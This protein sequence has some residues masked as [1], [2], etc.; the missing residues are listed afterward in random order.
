MSLFAQPVQLSNEPRIFSSL[1]NIPFPGF[2][3]NV[4]NFKA[5]EKN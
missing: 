2:L 1:Q 3:Q 4:N 5:F